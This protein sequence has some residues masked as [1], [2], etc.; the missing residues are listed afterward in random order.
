MANP[1]LPTNGTHELQE[2]YTPT[3]IKLKR[4][5]NVVRQHFGNDY[6][7]SP[8]AGAVKFTKRNTEV[9][10]NDYDVVL[11]ATLTTSTT[12]Y[13]NVLIKNDEAINELIDGYEA[14]AVPDNL[15][16]QRIESGAYSLGRSQETKAV[17][18][19]EN[20]GTAEATLTETATNDMYNTIVGSIKNLKKFG[21]KTN[22]M[23]IVISPDTE[24]K[25]LTDTKYSNTASTIGADL[26]RQGIVSKI[27]GVPVVLSL[28][29]MEEDT[30]Y[31]AGKLTTTEYLVFGK[32]WAQKAEDWKVDVMIN[33]IK[34]GKHIG[35]SALQGRI[36]YQD[37]LLDETTCRVKLY[38][39]AA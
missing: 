33:D 4:K 36:V 9:A 13:V 8:L 21:V 1:K 34:N 7:G 37:V 11:G 35:S 5:E 39:T 20:D 12:E 17:K 19:L 27:A 16:A 32:P 28:D 31:E 25:L 30:E 14:G 3:I 18:I 15:K 2:R 26:V 29:L 10:V 23:M 22:E 38:Q 24:E 6:T